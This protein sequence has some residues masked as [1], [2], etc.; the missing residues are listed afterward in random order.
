MCFEVCF[1]VSMKGLVNVIEN[2]WM[3]YVNLWYLFSENKLLCIIEKEFV[4]MRKNVYGSNI[5]CA[6]SNAWSIFW[7]NLY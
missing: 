7:E 6:V 3:L 2:M 4:M 5:G 1:N